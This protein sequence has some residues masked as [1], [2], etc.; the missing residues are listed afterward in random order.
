[1][2]SDT[3]TAAEMMRKM[4][5][6]ASPGPWKWGDG[7][8]RI[9]SM[10]VDDEGQWP[11]KYMDLRLRAAGDHVLLGLRI[12]HYSEMWD[13]DHPA[14]EMTRADRDLITKFRNA[15]P[16]LTELVVLVEETKGL[17]WRAVLAKLTEEL[18]R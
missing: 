10:E 16:V 8:E 1:M 7:W 11:K 5:K 3:K 2:A 12:D 18:R 13:S 9:E 4:D 14:H 17:K 15:L 6:A